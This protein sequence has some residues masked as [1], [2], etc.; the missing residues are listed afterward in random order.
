MKHFKLILFFL[1]IAVSA[2]R[3]QNAIPSSIFIID[4]QSN[5]QVPTTSET[6][7]LFKTSLINLVM[8]T[9]TARMQAQANYGPGRRNIIVT[10]ADPQVRGNAYQL[11]LHRRFQGQAFVIYTFLYSVDENRLYFYDPNSRNWI[12]QLIRGN[13]VL[14]LNNCQTYGTF[15]QLNV[16]PGQEIAAAPVEDD[17]DMEEADTSVSVDATPPPLPD[18]EQ[19]ECPQEGYL[20]QPGYWA[21]SLAGRDYYWVPGVWVAPPSVGVLW[22]PPYWGF[23][24]GVYVFHRGYWGHTIGFYG[25]V[26]YGYGYGGIGFVGGEWY[27]GHFRYNTAIVRVNVSFHN[28]YVDRTVYHERINHYSFNGRDGYMARPT[29]HEMDA[30]REHHEFATREQ[31]RN[32]QT[33]REDRTQFASHSGGRPSNFAVARAPERRMAPSDAPH[34]EGMATGRPA[35]SPAARPYRTAGTR[36]GTNNGNRGRSASRESKDESRKK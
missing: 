1:F 3:A 25:G 24:G 17:A 35:N 9:P 18:Y 22:T 19:P 10:Q 8:N 16:Q 30:E 28:V 26:D 6:A 27:E 23:V 13:N 14:N 34:R 32:Q 15:N 2:G 20:W 5:M 11:S 21:Y 36:Q 31:I 33:A 7:M 4:P 12:G 29:V